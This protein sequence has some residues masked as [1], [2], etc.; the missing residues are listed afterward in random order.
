LSNTGGDRLSSSLEYLTA[1]Y[2][3]LLVHWEEVLVSL[4]T[5]AVVL[6]WAVCIGYVVVAFWLPLRTLIDSLIA[7]VY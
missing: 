7:G 6:V 2:R 1:Y 3:S 5:P 4:L